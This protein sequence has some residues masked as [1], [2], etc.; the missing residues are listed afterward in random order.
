M[1]RRL[2]FYLS[3]KWCEAQT[4]HLEV[5]FAEWYADNRDAQQ[6]AQSNMV[7][8]GA[9]ATE[10]KPDDIHRYTYAPSRTAAF[11]HLRAE[12]P[13]AQNAQFESL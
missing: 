10:K 5:L 7:E 6:N 8:A 3:S 13:K 1:W 12:R 9:Y 4:R 11:L 2:P